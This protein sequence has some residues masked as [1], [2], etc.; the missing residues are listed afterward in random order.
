M[1]S[2]FV[3]IRLSSQLA[4]GRAASGQHE[5]LLQPDLELA[6]IQDLR[7]RIHALCKGRHDA[8]RRTCAM[9]TALQTRD[10]TVKNP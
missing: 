10:L 8:Q 2:S 5:A 7:R 9:P 3:H 4:T 6:R 1:A